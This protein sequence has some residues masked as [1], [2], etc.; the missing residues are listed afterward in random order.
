LE[1][2]GDIAGTGSPARFAL[3]FVIVSVG[4]HGPRRET[5]DD[6]SGWSSAPAVSPRRAV[7]TAGRF[8]KNGSGAIRR[9]GPE[10]VTRM[11]Q[12]PWPRQFDPDVA[13]TRDRRVRAL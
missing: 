2:A 9:A 11:P 3:F 5:R 7:R 8:T 1:H 6:R 4:L 10:Y 13:V 12:E